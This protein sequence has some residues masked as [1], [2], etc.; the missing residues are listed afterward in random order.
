MGSPQNDSTPNK[1]CKSQLLTRLA[2]A[3][4]GDG[5]HSYGLVEIMAISVV[6]I[7]MADNWAL[8]YED[9]ILDC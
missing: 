3:P 2:L 9:T 6:P 1:N 7:I 5:W 8:P 4:A